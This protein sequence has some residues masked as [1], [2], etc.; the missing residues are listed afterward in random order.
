[1]SVLAFSQAPL[2]RCTVHAARRLRWASG[3]IRPALIPQVL[4][5]DAD[6]FEKGAMTRVKILLQQYL[7]K[8]DI[9]PKSTGAS[10]GHAIYAF[11]PRRPVICCLSI[12]LLRPHYLQ[13]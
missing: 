13:D 8:A 4:V 3:A 6:S 5:D 11:G 7:P 10:L 2:M 9:R 1:M 12:A